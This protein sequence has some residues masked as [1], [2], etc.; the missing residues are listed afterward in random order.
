MPV[1]GSAELLRQPTDGF[2]AAGKKLDIGKACIHFQTAEDLALNVIGSII[3]SVPLARWVET[4]GS[5]AALGG[6]RTDGI[7][8]PPAKASRQTAAVTWRIRAA[9]RD[10]SRV[11]ERD[12]ETAEIARGLW[13]CSSMTQS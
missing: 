1:Y 12:L 2:M 11:A 9:P 6:N 5:Q 3:A 8:P 7:D 10:H 4:E 13:A